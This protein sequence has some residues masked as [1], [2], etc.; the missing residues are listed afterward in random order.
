MVNHFYPGNEK[1]ADIKEGFEKDLGID[2]A[3]GRRKGG[4]QNM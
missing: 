2:G 3:A 1:K 4:M